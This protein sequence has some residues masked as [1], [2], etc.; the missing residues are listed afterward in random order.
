MDK[1]TLNVADDLS[2][3]VRR[4]M[5]AAGEDVANRVLRCLH[6]VK[7][8]DRKKVRELGNEHLSHLIACEETLKHIGLATL[9]PDNLTPSM[10]AHLEE[11]F[12]VTAGVEWTDNQRAQIEAMCERNGVEIP[13]GGKPA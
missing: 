12:T 9:P 11:L 8:I 3:A 4:A 5:D 13:G 2:P 1:Q 6:I 7:N 10:A